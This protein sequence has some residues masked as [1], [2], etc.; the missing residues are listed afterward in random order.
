MA[1]QATKPDTGT[2]TKERGHRK[3]V[4]G[5]V[6]RARMQKTISVET[7]TKTKHPKYGKYTRR[8]TVMKAHDEKNEAKEGDVVEV[9]ETRPLSKTKRYRLIR[10]VKRAETGASPASPASPEAK[11]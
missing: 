11:P 9:M 1:N 2:E 7:Q 6:K 8:Y 3:L 5:I 10:I 4:Q